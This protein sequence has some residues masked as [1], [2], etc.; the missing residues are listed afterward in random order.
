MSR[1]DRDYEPEEL[2]SRTV[3]RSQES[4]GSRDDFNL[5]GQGASGGSANQEQPVRREIREPQPIERGRDK[6]TTHRFDRQRNYALRDSEIKTLTEIG[7]FRALNLNDLITHR[8]HGNVVEARRDL[9]NLERQGLLRRRT[10]YPENVSYLTLSKDAHRFLEAHP[11]ATA[12]ARQ[13]LYQGFVKP[14][15]ARHNAAIYR[16]YQQES[17]RI[18]REGGKVQRII[19]DFELKREVNQKLARLHSFP[20]EEQTRRKQEIAEEHHLPIVNG[21]ICLPDLRLE[22]EGP[23][24]ETA[25]VDLELVTGGYHRSGL[26][27]K[28]QTGFRMYGLPEDQ[29]RLRPAIS[30]PEIM[31]E[32]LSL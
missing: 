30:D 15:E 10:V 1:Y 18:W 14:K 28:A 20:A 2:N 31:L 7:A 32:V 21:R 29:A 9:D 26:A 5:R 4:S 8:Y 12:D 25:R 24:Q 6:R 17:A 3:P 23:D 27:R 13:A 22:Y 11:N 16:L 19:L